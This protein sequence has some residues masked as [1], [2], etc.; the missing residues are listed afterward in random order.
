MRARE[1][2]QSAF[3]TNNINEAEKGRRRRVKL[4]ECVRS[5]DKHDELEKHAKSSLHRSLKAELTYFTVKLVIITMGSRYH[6][7]YKQYKQ[8]RINRNGLN[9]LCYLDCEQSL[10]F[11]SVFRAIERTS[12]ERTSGEW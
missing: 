9:V 8:S 12:R 11:P 10:S 4:A 2:R 3:I 1:K 5:G 7:K 6:Q